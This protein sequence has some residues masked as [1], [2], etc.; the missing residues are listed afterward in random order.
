MP[1]CSATLWTSIWQAFDKHSASTLLIL[2]SFSFDLEERPVSVAQWVARLIY[3]N[4]H[5]VEE[6]SVSFSV[7]FVIWQ[8]FLIER[9]AQVY[10]CQRMLKWPSNPR[11]LLE[12]LS[13]LLMIWSYLRIGSLLT[14]IV[15]FIRMRFVCPGCRQT[16]TTFDWVLKLKGQSTFWDS[17]NWQFGRG[18]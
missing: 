2:L 12:S 16:P 4:E 15:W 11:R 18:W 14:I 8:L 5:R 10:I 9:R 17:K 1:L 7:K 13:T 6:Q 3:S